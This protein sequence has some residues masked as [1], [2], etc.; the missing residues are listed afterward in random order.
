MD[1]NQELHFADFLKEMLGITQD[2]GITQVEK[3]EAD[4]V[5]KIY[6]QYLPKRYKKDGKEYRL[7]DTTAERE[8]QH[9]SWFEYRCYL[10]CSLPR[11]IDMEGKAKVIE[12]IFAPKSK[13]YTHL[14]SRTLID[15][16]QKVR[17][18]KTVA[19]IL[20]TTPYIV[21]SVMEDCV[22]TSLQK[23]GLLVDLKN[24]SLDEKAYAQGHEYATI[25]I[26][27]DKEYV[28]E[29]IEGRK[30][31]SVK[32]LFLS[33]TG[34]EKLPQ[35]ER[36]NIDMWKPYMNAMF[37]I[38]PQALVVHDKF[39]L[40]KKLS[41]AIDKTR[42]EEVNE[43]PLLLK[44]KYTV[45]KNANNRS[46]K[47]NE[48]FEKINNANLKTAQAWHVRENFKTIFA[49]EQA[50]QVIQTYQIWVEHTLSLQ[51]KHVHTVVSTFERH[52][53]GIINAI[54]SKT[55]SGKHEN[56][57][58]KIQSVIAKARGFINFDR[59]RINVLFYFGKLD[60]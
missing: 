15:V 38:A 32:G 21:R 42:K 48:A 35:I 17:V 50:N 14:F 27:S 20:N 10:V 23:R 40:F 58:G 60:F 52:R 4:K 28:V 9:L 37:E 51:L 13:S 45:L 36:V 54:T 31:T 41:E 11:Y 8:W 6:L 24:I 19:E 53:Q 57:N 44:Q 29:L 39:H 25:L 55:T 59:F 16:L 7:Y 22:E 2:Y 1:K 5:I 56:M 18:Q 33:I 12:P 34:E 49:L 26:D 43:N 3:T 47:Q 30:E 46:D